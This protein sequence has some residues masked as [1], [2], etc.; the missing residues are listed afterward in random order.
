MTNYKDGPIRTVL[1]KRCNKCLE[2]KPAGQFSSNKSKPDW[3]AND[4]KDCCIQ[5]QQSVRRRNTKNGPSISRKRKKCPKCKRVKAASKYGEAPSTVDGLTA[6]C[7]DCNRKNSRLWAK[8]NKA[9][10]KANRQRRRAKKA[11]APGEY[12]LKQWEDRLNYWGNKCLICKTR[13]E[14]TIDHNIP[15]SRGGANWPSNLVPLCRPCNSGKRDK[16]LKEYRAILKQ[17]RHPRLRKAG[18]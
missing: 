7:A 10:V 15:L 5:Y 17:R 13:K 1:S 11:N 18:S 16:T 2:T 9:K 8:K 4:C 3:L 14:L 12:T 6:Y